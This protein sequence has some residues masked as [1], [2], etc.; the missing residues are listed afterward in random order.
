MQ[1]AY[2]IAQQNAKKTAEWGKECYNKRV[3]G[4]VVQPGDRMLVRNVSERGGPGKLR[5]HWE[6]VIHMVVD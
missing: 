3:S 4:G 5:S 1:E 6:H 2:Q